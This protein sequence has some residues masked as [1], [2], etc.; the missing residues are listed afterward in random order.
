MWV[1]PIPLIAL[2][3]GGLAIAVGWRMR[4]HPVPA[5]APVRNNDR[6]NSVLAFLKTTRGR[7][8]VYLPLTL[9]IGAL[10]LTFDLSVAILPAVTLPI[11]ATLFADQQYSEQQQRRLGVALLI[12]G[13]LFL[14]T[15]IIGV[16]VFIA[17]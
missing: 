13:V 11:W 3:I 5:T 16:A 17:R 15:L 8:A 6:P 9:L 12:A 14:V 2:L 10:W 4:T 7:I 1:A